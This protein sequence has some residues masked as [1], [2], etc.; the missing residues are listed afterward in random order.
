M[1]VSLLYVSYS[2]CCISLQAALHSVHWVAAGITIVS[3]RLD[4]GIARILVVLVGNRHEAKGRVVY[5]NRM[6]S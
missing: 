2:I 5:L 6:F 1:S 3:F 4:L